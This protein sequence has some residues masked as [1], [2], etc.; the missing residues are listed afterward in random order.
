MWVLA[1]AGVMPS[2]FHGDAYV[3][4][5]SD[6]R[7][8]RPELAYICWVSDAACGLL[9]KTATLSVVGDHSGEV[10]STPF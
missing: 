1:L 8:S 2:M 6:K 3:F 5:H 10:Q 9:L 4:L 7:D